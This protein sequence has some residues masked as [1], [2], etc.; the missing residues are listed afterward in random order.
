MTAAASS[1]SGGLAVVG[2]LAGAEAGGPRF[3]GKNDALIVM[4]DTK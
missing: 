2:V 3:A 4:L 1:E